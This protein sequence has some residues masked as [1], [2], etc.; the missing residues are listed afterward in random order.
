MSRMETVEKKRPRPRPRPRGDSGEQPVEFGADDAVALAG[1]VLEAVS[2]DDGHSASE[3]A[4]ESG[5][6]EDPG[7]DGYGGPADSEH[8][9]QEF[10]GEGEFVAAHPVV[11]EE[12][13]AA[14]PFLDGVQPVAGHLLGDLAEQ[15]L[16]VALDEAAERVAAGGFEERPGGPGHHLAGDLDLVEVAGRARAPRNTGTPTIPSLPMVAT[17]TAEPSSIVVRRET[18]ALTGK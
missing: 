16:G 12:H 7:G 17:S 14:A 15:R 3:V 13:P 9:G 4:D 8:L 1:G 6:L 10:L 2:V 11:G 18:T 5:L